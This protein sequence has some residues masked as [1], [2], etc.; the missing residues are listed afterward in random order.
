MSAIDH[1]IGTRAVASRLFLYLS[2]TDQLAVTGISTLWRKA[3]VPLLWRE[4]KEEHYSLVQ[5]ESLVTKYGQFI[6]SF[7]VLDP[8]NELTASEADETI[9]LCPN[10]KALI[11]DDMRRSSMVQRL[12]TKA[13]EE[14]GEQ[15]TR[16]SLKHLNF[17]GENEKTLGKNI[18]KTI[19]AIARLPNL[20]RLDIETVDI[21]GAKLEHLVASLRT[22]SLMALT[23]DV[24]EPATAK[25]IELAIE[26][27]GSM[28]VLLSIDKVTDDI[29][30]VLNKS[31]SRLPKLE[32]LKLGMFLNQS[33]SAFSSLGASDLGNLRV[34][35]VREDSSDDQLLP[36]WQRNW[37][38]VS[39][40][41]ADCLWLTDDATKLIGEGFPS[42]REFRLT[43]P[44]VLTANGLGCLL[45]PRL[46][47][48]HELH[49]VGPGV[50]LADVWQKDWP[51]PHSLRDVMLSVAHVSPEILSAVLSSP[52][53]TGLDLDAAILDDPVAIWDDIQHGSAKLEA[54][55]LANITLFDDIAMDKVVDLWK[56]SLRWIDV[57]ST[58]V[59]PEKIA[60]ISAAYPSIDIGYGQGG[61]EDYEDEEEGY[62]D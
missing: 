50:D 42:L 11:I 14:R 19:D 9:Q 59:S 58:R 13:V 8:D 34:L 27:Y 35:S 24:S 39:R 22:K 30:A 55:G 3:M 41:E 48:L 12:V 40:L 29:A 36:L 17:E 46:T 60:D 53:L 2:F 28:L 1:I 56:Q 20:T 5:F 51:Q 18:N 52:H 26:K 43:Y 38:R 32:T 21:T 23:I 49:I 25:A 47:Q 57:E 4:V 54:I 6:E 10:I 33:E 15:I 31:W 44:S 16:I 37:P 61:F 62:Y 7:Y 45:R